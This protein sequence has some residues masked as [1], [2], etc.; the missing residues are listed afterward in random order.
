MSEFESV[1]LQPNV[2]QPHSFDVPAVLRFVLGL[3]LASMPRF[4]HT[5]ESCEQTENSSITWRAFSCW[6]FRT[7]YDH[8]NMPWD[9][10]PPRGCG[11]VMLAF[12][13]THKTSPSDCDI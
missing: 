13:E 2:Q 3:S 8:N 9:G 11:P 4:S 12:L 6:S 10:R 5:Y 1:D 7:S